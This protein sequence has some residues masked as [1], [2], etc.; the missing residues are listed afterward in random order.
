MKRFIIWAVLTISTLVFEGCAVFVPTA[1]LKSVKTPMNVTVKYEDAQITPVKNET[2]IGHNAYEDDYIKITWSVGED[3]FYFNIVNK[4]DFSIII[5]WDRIVYINEDHVA[6][7]VIHGGIPFSEKDY[8]QM[9]TVVPS[10]AT[11]SSNLIP[12]YNITHDSDNRWFAYRLF[13]QWPTQEKAN[14]SGI[15]GQTVNIVFPIIIQ[16]VTHEYTFEFILNGVIN[17]AE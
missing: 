6:E 4:T 16:D 13:G 11:L 2:L 3:R 5:Q 10:K 14:A 15:V 9:E 12:K 17:L 1:V 7:R 8:A